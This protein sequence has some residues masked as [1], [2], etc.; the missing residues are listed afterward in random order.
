MSSQIKLAA[1]QFLNYLKDDE[2]VHTVTEK[3]LDAHLSKLNGRLR[4]ELVAL[5]TKGYDVSKA[6]AEPPEGILL[7]EGLNDINI[8]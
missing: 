7:L 3:N 5:Y 4:D 2:A 8:S 6:C 1:E